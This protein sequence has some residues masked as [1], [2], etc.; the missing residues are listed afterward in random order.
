MLSFMNERG[1]VLEQGSENGDLLVLGRGNYP[2]Q[3]GQAIRFFRRGWPTDHGSSSLLL[4][5]AW[6]LAD[7]GASHL[8]QNALC[9]SCSPGECDGQGTCQAYASSSNQPEELSKGPSIFGRQL[10][11][12]TGL[13]DMHGRRYGSLDRAES[14]LSPGPDA[15]QTRLQKRRS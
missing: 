5:G 14:S 3:S 6:R 13:S 2:K 8:Q 11:R 1:S 4:S 10:S 7:S 12:E 9:E 15:S